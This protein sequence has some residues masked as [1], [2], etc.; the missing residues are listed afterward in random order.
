MLHQKKNE[1]YRKLRCSFTDG[2]VLHRF[3]FGGGR[4]QDLAKA[5]G[6]KGNKTLNVV[7]TTGG[8]GKDAFLLA[9]LGAKVTLIERSK[10]MHELLKAGIE[11]GLRTDNEISKVIKR[12]TLIFGD[13]RLLLKDLSPDVILID[14]M[15]PPRKKSAQVN[16]EMRLI[17]KIVGDDLDYPELLK[18]AQGVAKNRVVLKLPRYSETP[19]GSLKVSHQIL[20]KSTR[21]DVFMI[22]KVT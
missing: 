18:I 13:S 7:D 16:L 11:E 3:K 12:M 20:G 9:S 6:F 21:Y 10:H 4:N 19:K 14:P 17:R 1:D 5:V 15:H 8:L 22:N 2:S